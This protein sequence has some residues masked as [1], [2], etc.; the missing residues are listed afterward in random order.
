MEKGALGPLEAGA[1]TS[2]PE[3][4]QPARRFDSP[5]VG[6]EQQL[7]ALRDVFASVVQHR[8][9]H[10]LTV[11]GPAGIG[12]SRLV[13]EFVGELGGEAT[14][15]HGHCL[16]YG[17]GITYWP[18]TEVV[19]EILRSAVPSGA[20][21]SSAAIAE[22]L[23]GEEKAGLI[24]ELIFDALG[25]GSAGGGTGEATSWAVRKLFEALAQRRPLVIVFDDLQWAEPTFLDL[26]GYLAEL[27]R[28][29]PILLLCMARPELFDSH[30]GWGGATLDAA[31]MLLEPLNDGDCRK[32]IANLLGRGPLPAD[33]ETWIAEAADG[34]ALFAE[35]LL[36]MLVDDDLLA[37]D[38]ARWVAAAGLQ[39]VPV[40]TTLTTLLAARLEGLPSDERALLV[41]ASVEGTQFHRSAIRELAREVP[42]AFLERSLAALVRRDVIRP[43]QSSFAG[44]EAYRFRHLLIRDAAYRSLSQAKRAE[45][46]ERLAAWLERM[47]ADRLGE[48]EEIVGYHLEQAYRC[49]LERGSADD[50]LKRLGAQASLRLEQAGRRALARGDLPAAIGLLERAA[51]LSADDMPRRA[52]LL[53]EIGAALIAAGRLSEADWVLEEARLVAARLGDERAESH[54]LVQLHF[55]RLLH[56]SA[57]GS[58][59]AALAVERVI[60]VFERWDDQRG[61][62]SARRLEAWLHWNE[63]RAA[64][65]AEAWECAAGHASSAA[66][67]HARAEILTWIASSLWFGPTPIV[68][69]IHRCEEILGEV[70]G[71]LDAEAL[72]LR[73]LAG[74]HAMNGHFDLARSLLATSNGVFEDLGLT[75]N[76]ATSH[77]EALIE[78]LAGDSAAA[79]RSLRSGFDALTEMGE[80]AFLSTTAAFLARAVFAQDRIDEAEDL[81]QLSAKLAATGDILTHVL[82][83]GVQA[84][85]LARRGR[86]ESAEELAREAVSLAEETDFVVYR[87]DALIDLASILQDSGRT[88]EAAAAAAAGLQ[89]HE[90]KGN[91]V[92]AAKIRTDLGDLL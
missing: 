24:A 62:C 36:A 89:L 65:A 11:L 86:L 38:G 69:G 63:A 40:P 44:D 14:V 39:A 16:P 72:T 48:F 29:A 5:L 27:S 20:E 53:P 80:Q 34:N 31:S 64:A 23:P 83:R 13:Q 75:L 82:W 28:S 8:A 92:T 73:H 59:E 77:N 85:V 37:W 57:G 4:R 81:A 56:V 78:M 76:A 42:E 74:L 12:K 61:L 50:E 45:Q 60:P 9:C 2:A 7:G 52:E 18:L 58:E 21:S 90:D 22:L 70:S 47:A 43:D 88:Q 10:L 66:D 87:G 1:D 25:L 41:L 46:H 84:R 49:R 79:E 26:L 68:E 35:E 71:H 15:L 32:L 33:A 3:E 17:E 91:L 55:L 6:R 54:V 51:S 67:E 19:R 30:P